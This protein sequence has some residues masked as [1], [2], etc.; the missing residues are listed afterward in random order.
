MKILHIN[1]SK[2]GGAAIGVKRFHEALKDRGIRSEIFYF[3]EYL[4]KIQ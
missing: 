3:S 4:K 2:D 1:F